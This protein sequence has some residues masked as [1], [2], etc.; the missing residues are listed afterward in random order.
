M[1]QKFT[2]LF[3]L[4]G[5]LV[6]TAP[7]LMLAHNHVMRKFGYPTKS[8]EDIRNLV[9]KGAGALIGRSIWGQAKKEF[10]KVLDEK[11]KDEMVKEFVNFYGKNIVNE[12]TLVNGVKEFLKWCKEQNISMAVCTNKQEHLSNDLLKKIGIYDFFEYVAGS[13][14]F[15]YCKPDPR[16][17]TNVVEILDG[18][19]KKTIMI[20]D[21]ETDANAAKAAEIPVILL[22]NGYT[23]KNTTEIYHNHLIKDFIGIE[24][25]I[26]KYL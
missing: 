7:D 13:D 26:T 18:D 23:E 15:D 16:H 1:K 3:D 4:D 25:I 8:T 12:S 22:E 6:D 24:K 14:T 17:L 20:G 11:I 5:T 9:G 2:I 10:S 19:I 21:S